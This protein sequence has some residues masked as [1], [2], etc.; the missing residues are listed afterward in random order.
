MAYANLA[1]SY[2]GVGESVLAAESATKAFQ[3]RERAS[4][5]ERFFITFNYDREVTGNL[6]HA[7]QT[8]ELW[9]QTYPRRSAPPDAMELLGGPLDQGHWTVGDSRRIAR[10]RRSP[11]IRTLSSDMAIWLSRVSFS[12]ASTR[13]RTPLQQAGAH[14]KEWLELPHFL[15]YRYNIAFMK[16]DD[17]EMDRTVALAK[18]KRLAE[19]W[20]TNSR[21]PCSSS[22]RPRCNWPGDYP[23]GPWIWLSRRDGVR[24]RRP[25]SPRR[26]YGKAFTGTPTRR[27]RKPPPPSR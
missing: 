18:G 8:L 21:G 17:D 23:A 6:E 10:E 2:S 24:R 5:R 12:T 25:I 14:K 27:G 20:V 11:P 9:E 19:H 26:R 22:F 16:G 3:L 1:L 13:Q 4:E 7:F 15:V